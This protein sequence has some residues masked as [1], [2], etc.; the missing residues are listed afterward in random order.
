M[1]PQV[2][3]I[4]YQNLVKMTIATKP[5]KHIENVLNLIPS[6]LQETRFR[7]ESLPKITKTRGADKNNNYQKVVSKLT[8]NSMKKQSPQ[9]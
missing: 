3:S 5:T 2:A 6:V 4:M 1:E 9:D 8:P 7:M